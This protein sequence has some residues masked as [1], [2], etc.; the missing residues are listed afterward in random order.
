MPIECVVLDLD[1][2]CTDVSREA[3]AFSAAF[4]ALIAD[5]LGRDLGATWEEAE[6]RVR[7]AS[8]ELAW[9]MDGAAIAPADADPYVS[10][11]CVAQ[12]LL[13]DAGVLVRDPSLR[14]EVISAIYRRAYRDT[15]AAF[16]P[17]ARGVIEALIDLGVAVRVVTNAATEVAASK[18][19]HLAPRGL[20]RVRVQ[21]DARKFK[22]GPASRS[23]A[24]FEALPDRVQ[25]RGLARPVLLRRGSY[26]DILAAIWEDTGATPGTTLV[27]G[28]IFEMDL[29]MPAALGAAVHLVRR[30]RTY[31]YE[32]DAIA[33]LGERGGVSEGLG[34]IPGRVAASLC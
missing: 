17:E 30:E 3:P 6:R 7:E 4:P 34:P 15:G 33:G 14:S 5:L 2:T 20:D 21:G 16:R 25:L 28:D 29:A 13:D 19:A 8:P 32:I 24:R 9:V 26:F 11:S 12:A 1:G 27:C 10:A 31:A 22:I 18:L 23:D